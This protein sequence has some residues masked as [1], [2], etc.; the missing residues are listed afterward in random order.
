MSSI[1]TL[2][3]GMAPVQ[4]VPKPTPQ[5]EERLAEATLA[6]AS[7]P[8]TVSS[9]PPVVQGSSHGNGDVHVPVDDSSAAAEVAL[10]EEPALKVRCWSC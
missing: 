8:T 2:T 3:A 6:V 9:T 7:P 1:P 10:P 5:A 4:L